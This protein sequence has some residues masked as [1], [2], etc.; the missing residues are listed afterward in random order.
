M[1]EGMD[2]LGAHLQQRGYKIETRSR[3]GQIRLDQSELA[4]D[5]GGVSSRNLPL[6]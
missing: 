4:V 2:V 3:E 5:Y 6:G 1:L